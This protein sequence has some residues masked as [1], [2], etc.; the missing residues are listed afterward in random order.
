MPTGDAMS[1]TAIPT[2]SI[3]ATMLAFF[4]HD[5]MWARWRR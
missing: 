2:L 3:L 5:M 1:N 4:F